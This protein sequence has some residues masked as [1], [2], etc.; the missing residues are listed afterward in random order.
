MICKISCSVGEIIDKI[1]ILQ[2]KSNKITNTESKKN[3][4][5]ELSI[6]ISEN[7]VSNND[8]ILFDKLKKV[9]EKLWVLEDLIRD[10]SKKCE[11]DQLYINV[12]ESIHKTNDERCRIKKEINIKY[13]S[14]IIE[15]K[16]Y[17]QTNNH[18]P[19]IS[20]SESLKLEKAKDNYN[21]GNYE[22]SLQTL[23]EL[24]EIHKDTNVFT[25]F[26]I[27]LLFSYENCLSMF[28]QV[29]DYSHKIKE[30][31]DNLDTLNI[32]EEQKDFC[33]TSYASFTL[34]RN[35][36]NDNSIK[37]LN[38]VNGPNVHCRNMSFFRE[39]DTNKTILVYDGGGI[40]D[41]FMLARF[42]PILC[43]KYKS[44]HIIFFVNDNV[45][46]FFNECFKNI[47]NY[48]TVAYSTPHLL[49]NFDYHCSL[50]SL[51]LYLHIDYNSI[52]FTPL[53]KNIQ[54][55]HTKRHDE[56]IN[57]ITS[58]NK[59]NFVLNWKG[60]PNNGHEIHNRRM[61]LRYAIPLFELKHINWIVITKD[62]DQ[63]ELELLKKY[64]VICIGD[65]IDNG[66]NCYEDSISI[67]KHVDGVF[68]TDTSML[69][70]SANLDVP[71]Y[72]LLTLGA[73]WR[74]NPKGNTTNWYPNITI[75][76]QSKIQ[77]WDN[78]INEML[79]ILHKM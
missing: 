74:W 5:H 19:T 34:K 45:T 17:N 2:I 76:R 70:L 53:L 22:E 54:Y 4:E 56:I 62:I 39:N 36:Y 42:I 71:T 49:G 67:I 60:N 52:P 55:P 27:D 48:K 64:N 13:K 44:N 73:E 58:S 30:I 7:P 9:N 77:N 29:N 43:E 50:L 69:H 40:G 16:G 3:V 68:S 14:D 21:K 15:E 66:P 75:I 31:I 59:K 26:F 11:F 47:S 51:I 41:K 72:A 61:D 37:L 8:D 25:S 12:S 33:E 18:N 24:I 23:R 35:I 20:S 10:K 46:W 32:S 6:L 57:K 38:R 78:V 63:T 28:N 1:S 79:R 65:T